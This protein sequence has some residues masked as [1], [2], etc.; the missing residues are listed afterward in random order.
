MAKKPKM[1]HVDELVWA[2]GHTGQFRV[3]K[4]YPDGQTADLR[5]ATG[6]GPIISGIPWGA[7]HRDKEDVNQSAA[8][9]R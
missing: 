8:R 4:I 3:L 5:L 2:D 1:P 7:L 6:R 9:D